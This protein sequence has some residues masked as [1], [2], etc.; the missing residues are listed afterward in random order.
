MAAATSSRPTGRASPAFCKWYVP[1]QRSLGLWTKLLLSLVGN[2]R[3]LGSGQYLKRVNVLAGIRLARLHRKKTSL[4]CR[5]IKIFKQLYI[6]QT[7]AFSCTKKLRMKAGVHLWTL[8]WILG[9]CFVK[10]GLMLWQLRPVG[11]VFD[12]KYPCLLDFRESPS[13]GTIPS[14]RV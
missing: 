10:T 3:P 11:A 2:L 9:F 14:G 1:P 8:A 7:E 6:M 5:L 4:I 13:L 12:G